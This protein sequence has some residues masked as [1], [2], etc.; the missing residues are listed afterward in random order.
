MQLQNIREWPDVKEYGVNHIRDPSS[1]T[2][3]KFSKLTLKSDTMYLQN[4]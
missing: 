3:Q 2:R 1:N 4:L